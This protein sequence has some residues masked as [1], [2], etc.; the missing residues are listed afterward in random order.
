MN[1][2]LKLSPFVLGLFGFFAASCLEQYDP[3]PNNARFEA[4]RIAASQKHE[5]LADNG[6]LPSGPVVVSIDDRFTQLCSTC[7]G[8]TGH[9]DGPAGQA[10]N[11]HPR[12]FTDAAWQNSVD[13][14][15]IAKVITN[16]GASVGLSP[17]MAPWGSVL[18][19]AEIQE[20]VKKV[21]SFKGS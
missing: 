17:S 9:G 20:M 14:E 21:R 8:P 19:A 11:P 6:D 3:K 18:S 4:E 10:L 5:K 12:N 1:L 7:H 15:H 13:D 16:G 2:R